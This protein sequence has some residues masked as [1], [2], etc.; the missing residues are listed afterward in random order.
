MALSSSAAFYDVK[1]QLLTLIESTHPVDCQVKVVFRLEKCKEE[2][3]KSV[4]FEYC[5]AK[6]QT[7][8][9]QSESPQIEIQIRILNRHISKYSGVPLPFD[10]IVWL[11]FPHVS[12]RSLHMVC[13]ELV[14]LMIVRMPFQ[15]VGVGF[16]ASSQPLLFDKHCFSKSFVLLFRLTGWNDDARRKERGASESRHRH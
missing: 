3:C 9:E 1:I 11:T 5:I 15:C 12:E 7:P 16:V 2:N 14:S 13:N 10:P 8:S 4:C 6:S